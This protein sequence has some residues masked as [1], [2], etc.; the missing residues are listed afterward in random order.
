[1][2]IVRCP[3]GGR[4]PEGYCKESCLNYPGKVDMVERTRSRGAQVSFAT[5][6]TLRL[7]SQSEITLF[8]KGAALNQLRETNEETYQS[9][10][11]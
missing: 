9:S 6:K 7:V 1:M 11:W 3:K 4:V 8:T 2:K 5:R 10:D